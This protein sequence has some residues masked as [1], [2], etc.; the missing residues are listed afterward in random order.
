MRKT[1]IIWGLGVLFFLLGGCSETQFTENES[2]H[3]TP[4]PNILF[5]A[6]DDL[7]PELGA[8]GAAHIH[9]PHIDQLAAQSLV[10][11]RAYCN[12]PVCGASRA[13]LLSGVRPGRFRFLGY[14]TY[15]DRDYPGVVS[16]PKHFKANG[17]QTISNGKIYHHKD[18][19]ATAWDE[20]WRPQSRSGGSWRDYQLPENI[21]RDTADRARGLPYERAAVPDTAY[22]DGRIAEKSLRDLEQLKQTGKPFFLAVG[23][24][25]PHLPFNAPE[26]YWS[27]YDSSQISLPANYLQPPSTPKEA[28]HRFGELR[29]YAEVPAQGPVSEK[30]AKQ[31]IQ[32]Y[33]A[34][35]SYVDAQI[36]RVLS[37]LKELGLEENTI[38]I[39][40]GD[41]GW[42]LGDHQLWCKHCNFASSLHVPLLLKVP[43]KTNGQR[44]QAITEYIDIYPSLCELAGLP[45]P[46]HVDGESVVSI[47]EGRAR[48]KD[49]AISKYHNGVTLI[50]DSLFYTEWLDEENQVKARML[51]DHS[52]DPLELN[53]LGVIPEYQAEMKERSQV[54]QTH[55]GEDFFLDR[56]QKSENN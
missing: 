2:K 45:V 50:Q 14:S 23:F 27:L 41:H 4:P 25:K 16:L 13:S 7:R 15:L 22:Y 30:M 6:V 54:L 11:E 35:V 48:K 29:A 21:A 8:Y 37:G 38:V 52:A 51:F 24:L 49:Y 39:L 9:S 42:N 53:N 31:L 33:Y 20:V 44:T 26:A 55:W 32:G 18:D 36:G 1:Q 10:F 46:K 3:S 43:G 5:I 56:R 12:I 40:W 17:Y 19:D 34:C 28:F 47:L